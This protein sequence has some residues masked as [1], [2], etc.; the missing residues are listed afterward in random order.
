M[1][2][3]YKEALDELRFSPE[4][5]RRMAQRIEV[6]AVVEPLPRPTRR[7]RALVIAAAAAVLALAVGCTA[8][9]S[10][11]LGRASA[12]AKETPATTEVVDGIG[13]P[14]AHASSDG[15]TVTAEAVMGDRSNYAIVFSIAKDDGT[16]FEGI[17]ENQDGTLAL[18]FENLATVTVDDAPSRG[19]VSYFFD[20]DPHDNAIQFVKASTIDTHGGTSF[21]GKDVYVKLHDLLA[22]DEDGEARTLVEGAWKMDFVADCAD[23]SVDLPAG[24][25]F[26]FDEG[27]ATI[28]A[29]MISPLS[30]SVDLTID[31]PI[32]VNVIGF[33][34]PQSK[35]LQYL[36]LTVNMKDGTVIDATRKAGGGVEVREQTTVTDKSMAFDKILDLDQ[37]KS[38]TVGGVEIPMP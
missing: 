28:N 30:L 22:F 9:A 34:T 32:E 10:G 7:S 31:F 19:T 5:K 14:D 13:R 15:V 20:A 12:P 24:Q 35:R 8:Y 33:D 17:R 4:A 16:P 2:D 11:M 23:L 27:T 37:V 3:E 36:P 6:A 29:I 1:I 18:R 25:T 26:A 38:V 21:V